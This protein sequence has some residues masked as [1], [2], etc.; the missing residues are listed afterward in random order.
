MCSSKEK[1][2]KKIANK[3]NELINFI[4]GEWEKISL[5]YDIP[6]LIQSIRRRLQTVIYATGG[7]TKY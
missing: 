6:K 2:R 1:G 4:K 7:H 5:E 3:K